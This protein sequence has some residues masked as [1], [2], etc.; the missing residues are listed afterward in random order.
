MTMP[1]LKF[2][3]PM[4]HENAEHIPTV[5]EV[6]WDTQIEELMLYT[7]SGWA[8]LDSSDTAKS[9]QKHLNCRNC[10]APVKDHKCEYCGSVNA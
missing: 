3:S 10:G 6:S 8:I 5:G 4:S 9:K 2:I 1:A 7:A